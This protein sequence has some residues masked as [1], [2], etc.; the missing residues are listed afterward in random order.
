MKHETLKTLGAPSLE[1]LRATPAFSDPEDFF[2]RPDCS[3]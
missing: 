2:T 3:D 1:E